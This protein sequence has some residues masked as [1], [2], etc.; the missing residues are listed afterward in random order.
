MDHSHLIIKEEIHKAR[1]VFG[2]LCE[3][4]HSFNC[5]ALAAVENMDPDLFV[6]WC[7]IKLVPDQTIFCLPQWVHIMDH[8]RL[9][10]K[11]EQLKQLE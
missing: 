10:M 3:L 11:W 5:C 1:D 6:G 9:E 8:K 7:S 2:K 4:S